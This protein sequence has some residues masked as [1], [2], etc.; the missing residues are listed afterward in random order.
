[1]KLNEWLNLFYF[2]IVNE[3]HYSV[4]EDAES[5]RVLSEFRLKDERVLE[6]LRG[7]AIAV[8]GNFSGCF[9]VPEGFK[10]IT[11]G[12][13]V[14]RYDGRIDVHVTDLDEGFKALCSAADRARVVVVHAHGDNR[15]LIRDFVPSLDRVV[16]TTQYIPFERVYN[17][18]GFT[19]GDRAAIIAKKFGKVRLV[20]FNFEVAESD[21][22]L[23]KL[24]WAKKI[25]EFEGLL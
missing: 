21:L 11:A 13:A 1:M 14:L 2:P 23:K 16:G 4:A 6:F 22:K 18:G 15:N 19:D 24:R 5:A 3:F 25:L 7:S 10:V 8:V 12:K 9:E 17:F 20:N